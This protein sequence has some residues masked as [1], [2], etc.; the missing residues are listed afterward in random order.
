MEDLKYILT[1]KG[2]KKKISFVLVPLF[3]ILGLFII[4]II[5]ASGIP[6]LSSVSSSQSYINSSNEG[7][8]P[9][10][11]WITSLELDQDYTSTSVDTTFNIYWN[12]IYGMEFYHSQ[13]SIRKIEIL[14]TTV[15]SWNFDF[16]IFWTDGSGNLNTGD[17]I[18]TKTFSFTNG[19]NLEL[20]LWED[21]SIQA[22]QKYYFILS[23]PTG[24]S[25]NKLVLDGN[26]GQIFSY[27]T[28]KPNLSSSE[29]IKDIFSAIKAIKNFFIIFSTLLISILEDFMWKKTQLILLILI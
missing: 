8:F 3:V 1:Q 9:I 17:V 10:T 11:V 4:R 28:E 12:T 19:M 13:T 6:S 29:E 21:I 18:T 26:N 5:Y 25:S 27:P 14:W 16:K 7:N 23:N 22:N 15:W 24:N 20:D 2:M